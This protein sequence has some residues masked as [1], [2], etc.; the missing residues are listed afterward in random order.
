MELEL[1]LGLWHH[2][3]PSQRRHANDISVYVMA[4]AVMSATSI[5]P[6][7]TNIR[8]CSLLQHASRVL[9]TRN[10]DRAGKS[11]RAIIIRRMSDIKRHL[12]ELPIFVRPLLPPHSLLLLDLSHFLPRFQFPID[13]LVPVT[14]RQE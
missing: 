13:D 1:N 7:F 12:L 8:V 2:A 9:I 10:D 5:L 6:V 11:T 4:S 3:P 14:V